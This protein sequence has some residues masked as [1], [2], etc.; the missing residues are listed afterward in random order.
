[1]EKEA[2]SGMYETDTIEGDEQRQAPWFSAVSQR[3]LP[4]KRLG[5]SIP[6][7]FHESFGAVL[8]EREE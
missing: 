3:A 2:L 5:D 7:P 4:E 8:F 1:M 6:R